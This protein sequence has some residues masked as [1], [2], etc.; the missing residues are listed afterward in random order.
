MGKM[1]RWE[2][3]GKNSE[4]FP[5]RFHKMIMDEKLFDDQKNGVNACFVISQ[6]QKEGI[7]E[8]FPCF[9]QDRVIVA[10]NGI[11][12]V[13]FKEPFGL[14]FVECMAYKAPVVGANSGGP[15]DFVTPE[16]GVLV[17]EPKETK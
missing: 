5:M 3:G 9:P 8:I 7:K 10:P 2:L 11:N 14:V 1:Y 6:E 15:K 4:E 17:D 16:V 13:K 12:V